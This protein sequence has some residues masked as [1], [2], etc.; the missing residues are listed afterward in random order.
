M[1]AASFLKVNWRYNFLGI[2]PSP[3]LPPLPVVTQRSQSMKNLKNLNNPDYLHKEHPKTC[4]ADDFWGQVSRTVGG[5]PV[6]EQQINMIVEAITNG[7]GF[8]SNDSLLD[9][10]CGNGALSHY[11]FNKI[12]HYLGVDFSPYLIDIAKTNFMSAPTHTFLEMDAISY[13]ESE[14]NPTRFNKLL[15]Y[16]AFAYLSPSDAEALLEGIAKKFSNIDLIYIGNLPD[17]NRANHFFYSEKDY[18]DG[19]LRNH[20]TP[21]GIWRSKEEFALM[22]NKFGWHAEFY[23]MPSSFYSAH[24][25]YDAILTRNTSL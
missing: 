15:C 24:Y 18:S 12:R 13:M 8:T 9:I 14:S 5:V 20:Q 1:T 3:K 4:A 10:G 19:M 25:R 11:Y 22:A 17:R 7:L 21:I 6:T 23:T 2:A 16:G